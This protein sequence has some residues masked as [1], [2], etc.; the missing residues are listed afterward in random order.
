MTV[1]NQEELKEIHL[2][3]WVMGKVCCKDR[4]KDLLDSSN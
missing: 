1:N 2:D 3:S 4:G